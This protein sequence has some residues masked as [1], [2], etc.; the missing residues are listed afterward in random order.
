[1]LQID[2]GSAT[3]AYGQ[4]AN[5]LRALLVARDLEPGEQLPTVRQ[6]AVDLGVHHN[7]VAEA[8]RQL[9]SEGWL[10]LKRGRGATVLERPSPFPGPAARAQFTRRLE[11]LLAKA[12]TDGIS[13]GDLAADLRRCAAEVREGVAR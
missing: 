10:D 5:G 12:I 6:L 8:Y 9:A 13:R 3:P 7:T 4:I 11:E 2:L 1:M